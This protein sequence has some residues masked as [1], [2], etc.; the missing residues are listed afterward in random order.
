LTGEGS[1]GCRGLIEEDI[2]EG[3]LVAAA[4]S[5]WNVPLEI[6]LYRDAEPLGKAADAFWNTAVGM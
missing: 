3:R 4:S 6:R 2:D 1:R 5:D